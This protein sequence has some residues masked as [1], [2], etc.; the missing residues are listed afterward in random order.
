MVRVDDR[1]SGKLR[2]LIEYIDSL[3]RRERSILNAQ[4]EENRDRDGHYIKT[5]KRLLEHLRELERQGNLLLSR[6]R[7]GV[8]RRADAE[9]LR[10]RCERVRHVLPELRKHRETH[11]LAEALDSAIVRIERLIE[12]HGG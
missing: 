3:E 10:G 7:S 8:R 6:E 11:T 2:T 5:E 9:R 1:G 12:R 4:L